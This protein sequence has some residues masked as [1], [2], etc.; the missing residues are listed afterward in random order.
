MTD[1]MTDAQRIEFLASLGLNQSTPAKLAPSAPSAPGGDLHTTPAAEIVFDPALLDGFPELSGDGLRAA[2][3]H[4]FN[5]C[6][7]PTK[8]KDRH[9][10]LHRRITEFIGQTKLSRAT[11]GHV[12]EKI[13][14]TR[15]QRDLAALIAAKGIT[16]ADLVAMLDASKA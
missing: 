2:S 4:V 14:T 15:E 6:K 11:G 1:T 12:K 5:L 3:A 13:T 8:D 7:S 10:L 16:V 9:S